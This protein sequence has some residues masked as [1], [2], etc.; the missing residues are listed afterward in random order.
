MSFIHYSDL[1]MLSDFKTNNEDNYLLNGKN[2]TDYIIDS[3]LN[4]ECFKV[5][6]VFRNKYV[7]SGASEAF[8]EF[9]DLITTYHNELCDLAKFAEVELS[10]NFIIYRDLISKKV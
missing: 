4:V 10:T 1:D 3:K 7:H 2:I 6:T 8:K 9:K 5:L